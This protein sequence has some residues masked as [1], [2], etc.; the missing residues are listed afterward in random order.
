MAEG[1]VRRTASHRCSAEKK[2]CKQ[3]TGD[4]CQDI[5]NLQLFFCLHLQSINFRNFLVDCKMISEIISVTIPCSLRT[6]MFTSILSSK[7]KLAASG[8]DCQIITNIYLI[9]LNIIIYLISLNIIIYLISLNIIIYLISL[10]I[11]IY[12]ILLNI[13]E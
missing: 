3:I 7:N 9:S 4:E 2:I 12:L 13:R 8:I 5:Y 1:P 11:I 10:N 6:K